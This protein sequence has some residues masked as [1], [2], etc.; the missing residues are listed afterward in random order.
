MPHTQILSEPASTRRLLA[1]LSLAIDEAMLVRKIVS[2]NDQVRRIENSPLQTER[3]Q[4]LR[5]EVSNLEV[6][7][8]DVRSQAL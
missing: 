4:F 6:Q 7:L 5:R 1:N 2:L 8:S 3:V